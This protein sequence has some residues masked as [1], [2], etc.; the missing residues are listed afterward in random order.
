MNSKLEQLRK[1]TIL[2]VDTGDIETI[3]DFS[4]Q[5]ATTNQSLIL[6]A[7]KTSKYSSLLDDA[8]FY[9]KEK[10]NKLEQQIELASLKLCVNF[11]K[12]ILALIPGRIST[13]IDARLSYNK[14][15]SIKKAREIIKL[16]KDEGIEKDRVLI[17]LASTWEGIRAAETL[18]TE[19]I[20]CNLT[21]LFSFAQAR[22]C[23]EANVYL[24]QR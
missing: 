20:N 16:Y 21:L 3:A 13:E 23:A 12:E 8:V 6:K 10:S 9:A 19:G 5:D 18:E 4:P 24:I 17:K 14:E 7:V 2:V 22:A 1:F 15:E 11:G